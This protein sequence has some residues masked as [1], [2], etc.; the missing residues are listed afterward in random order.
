[1]FTGGTPEGSLSQDDTSIGV[2]DL[3][4]MQGE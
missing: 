4:A 3:E 1:M 2:L